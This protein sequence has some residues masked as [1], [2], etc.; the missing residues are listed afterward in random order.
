MKINKLE[1]I[2]N[3]KRKLKKRFIQNVKDNAKTQPKMKK[4]T[5]DKLK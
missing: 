1:T 3:N 4:C 2:E 5:R